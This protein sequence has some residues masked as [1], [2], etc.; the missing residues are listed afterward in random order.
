MKL[1]FG[2]KLHRARPRSMLRMRLDTHL[3]FR[4]GDRLGDRLCDQVWA[5]LME[6]FM[7]RLR[8]QGQHAAFLVEAQHYERHA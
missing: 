5:R 4:L 1:L 8:G 6:R 3:W 7:D 2:A